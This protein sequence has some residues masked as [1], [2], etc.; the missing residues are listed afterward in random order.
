MS[1]CRNSV[2]RRLPSVELQNFYLLEVIQR[3]VAD[4]LS[5]VGCPVSSYKILSVGDHP[6]IVELLKFR[7]L[8]VTQFLVLKSLPTGCY[9][10]SHS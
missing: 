4:I 3:R 5:A 7:P 8:E 9:P 10:A 2:P 1:S 6:C